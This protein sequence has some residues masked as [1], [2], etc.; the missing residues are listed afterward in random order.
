[1]NWFRFLLKKLLI[2]DSYIVYYFYAKAFDTMISSFK[3]EDKNFLICWHYL[4]EPLSYSTKI[5]DSSAHLGHVCNWVTQI[6]DCW[7]FRFFSLGGPMS[8]TTKIYFI[9]RAI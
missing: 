7:Q 4:F 5:W 8:H 3:F 6:E 2:T 9:V 1:M